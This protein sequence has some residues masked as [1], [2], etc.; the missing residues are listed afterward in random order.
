MPG[1]DGYSIKGTLLYQLTSKVLSRGYNG[2]TDE[3][4]INIITGDVSKYRAAGKKHL[5]I[6]AT[7]DGFGLKSKIDIKGK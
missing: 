6:D 4:K 7:V 1:E 2:Y 3:E 5:F